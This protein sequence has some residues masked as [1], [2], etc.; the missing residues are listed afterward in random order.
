LEDIDE[1]LY[2]IRTHWKEHYKQRMCSYRQIKMLDDEINETLQDFRE[3]I[4]L[5]PGMNSYKETG[6]SKSIVRMA[7]QRQDKMTRASLN[8]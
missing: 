7:V 1:K 4:E 6:G 2:D 8:M 5:R 3:M